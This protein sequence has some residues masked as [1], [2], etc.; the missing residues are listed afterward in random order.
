MPAAVIAIATVVA[1]VGSAVAAAVGPVVAAI[2]AAVGPAVAA[3][4]SVIG[5]ITSAIGG[6]LAPIVST[7]GGI[8]EWVVT[9]IGQTVSGLVKTVGNAVK[10]FTEGLKEA[11]GK[12]AAGIDKA[13]APILDP[14]KG[15][16]EVVKAKVDA[17]ADW[18]TTAF[19][20]SA[21]LAELRATHPEIWD[22][23]Q[24][25]ND[26]FIF[27]LEEMGHISSTKAA[28]LALPDVIQTITMVSTLKV[29]ADL[30]KGQ[31][32][33]SDLLGKIADGK[34]FET[35]Q[36]IAMLSQSIAVTTVGIMDRVDTEIEILRAGIET[37]DERLEASVRE[38]IELQKAQVLAMVTPKMTILG[39]HSLMLNRKI[40][41]LSRHIEDEHWF[42]LMLIRVLTKKR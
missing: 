7:V 20:P 22:L 5:A 8:A 24:Y 19:H 4:G 14:I 39:E 37:F 10:P 32:S 36:A 2:A 41:R 16:L 29:L 9:S 34:G 33:I 17:V 40:A 26:T 3:I 31:A 23:A 1:G 28:L 18:V 21:E 27:H 30:V 13:T 35:A 6:A 25:R 15:A 12:L 38:A 42:G 11:I